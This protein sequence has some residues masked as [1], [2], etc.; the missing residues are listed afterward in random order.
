MPIYFLVEARF[1]ALNALVM[2]TGVVSGI[3]MDLG[4]TA[5]AAAR[6]DGRRRA[7][8]PDAA[9]KTKIPIGEC[10]DRAYVHD[11]SRIGII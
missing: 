11:I 6:T 8:E 5:A 7:E 10:A 1:Q 9:L 3:V 2:I 4:I